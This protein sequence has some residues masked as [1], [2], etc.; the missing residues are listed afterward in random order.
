MDK[1]DCTE[2]T[3]KKV[4]EIL[5][6]RFVSALKTIRF[7]ELCEI[8]FRTGQPVLMVFADKKAYLN[9]KGLTAHANH[10]LVPTYDEIEQ[11]VFW[12]CDKSVYACVDQLLGGFLP[13]PGGG[14]IGVCGQVMLDGGRPSALN[15]FSSV[16][17]RIPH[18]V[19]DCALPVKKFYAFPLKNTLV[20]SK[21]FCGKTTFLR[22]MVYQLR[23]DNVN[24][25]IIDERQEIAGIKNGKSLFGLNGCCDV[26]SNCPKKYAVEWGVRS[27]A[28]QVV[29]CDELFIEDMD[30]VVTAVESGIKFFASVH[31]DSI[32][33]AANKL[34]LNEKKTFERFVLLSD[35]RGVGTIDGVYDEEFNRLA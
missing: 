22:D 4:M 8:R 28:P 13:L 1:L 14:R 10:A 17:V 29:V 35:K 5:P 30:T 32:V 20:I 6:S 25:L 18:N 9:E 27:M 31:A 15:G 3:I 34:R 2:L 23:E 7:D 26:L 33:S 21:P 19:K 24:V 11:M 16:N 12:A